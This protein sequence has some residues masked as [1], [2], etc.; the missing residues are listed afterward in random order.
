MKRC[1]ALAL[2]S[3]KSTIQVLG[4]AY[5]AA[6]LLF[7]AQLLSAVP[8]HVQVQAWT[9][10]LT[11]V[12]DFFAQLQAMDLTDVPP[13]LRVQTEAES[14]LRNDEES[15][16]GAADMLLNSVPERD[17]NFVKVPRIQSEA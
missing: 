12:T 7:A 6:Y 17:G 14:S 4:I 13:T 10:Q 15:K 8:S 3:R 2:Q 11:K 1:C 16:H 5:R 9:P